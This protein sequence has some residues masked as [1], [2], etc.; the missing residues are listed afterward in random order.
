MLLDKECE[1]VKKIIESDYSKVQKEL[2]LLSASEQLRAESKKEFE[3]LLYRIEHANNMYEAIA[4]KTESD[5]LK[6]RLIE[7]I[8]AEYK[9]RNAAAGGTSSG[10]ST[11]GED[12]KSPNSG[13]TTSRTIN[14]TVNELFEE[15][16]L[17][18]N[19]EDIDR[20]LGELK[21]KLKE[22]LTTDTVI[23]LL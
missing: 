12:N 22:K 7:K 10:A 13:Y 21:H 8:N 17:I 15:T 11:I 3:N 9:K 5:R 19:D 23:K 16:W 2:D 6:I 4:M 18:R 1:P 20:L 14:I